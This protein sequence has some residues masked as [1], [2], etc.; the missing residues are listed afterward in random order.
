MSET[1]TGQLNRIVQMIAE[2]SR[3]EREGMPPLRLGDV[4][5][6]MGVSEQQIEKDIRTLTSVGEDA[7]H[8]WISSLSV[9]QEGDEIALSSQGPFR[10]PVRLTPDELLAIQIGLLSEDGGADLSARLAALLE[11]RRE[12]A[13]AVHAAPHAGASEARIVDLAR[14]AAQQH[15]LLELVY[16]GGRGGE[17]SRRVVEVHGVLGSEGKFY[18]R[19]W[20]RDA[21]GERTF[22]ADRVLE[23][24]LLEQSFAP[25]QV[26]LDVVFTAAADQLEE[27][28]VRFHPDIAR[29]VAEE[30]PGAARDDDGGIVVR[31]QVSEPAWLVRTVLGYGE[32]AEVLD[33]PE[34]RRMLRSSLMG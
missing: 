34:Y 26:P 6:R 14:L 11:T 22:R 16:T 10:R 21:D 13:D 4:A 30:H 19:C 9:V 27:V 12:G 28:R 32:H 33:P 1:A 17:P 25:R 24:R 18:L 2:L 29:W 5:A 7:E 20:C 31:Y 3:R 23:A 15:R 8:D